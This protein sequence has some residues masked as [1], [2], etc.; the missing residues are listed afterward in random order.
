VRLGLLVLLI[1]LAAQFAFSLLGELVGIVAFRGSLLNMTSLIALLR[2]VYLAAFISLVFE[3]AE[4]VGFALCLFV[5]GDPGTRRMAL[6][7]LIVVGL[8]DLL[9][10]PALGMSMS[11]TALLSPEAVDAAVKSGDMLGIEAQMATL[12]T[13]SERMMWLAVV[14]GIIHYAQMIVVPVFLRTLVLELKAKALEKDCENLLWLN[15]IRIFVGIIAQLFMRLP[16]GVAML[17]FQLIGPISWLLG[18]VQLVWY[19]LL[20]FHIRTVIR[21]RFG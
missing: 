9:T 3:C 8:S 17:L 21:N 1:V 6:V 12:L 14:L 16:L 15:A 11:V 7:T 10:L 20:L 19:A 4:L 13:W 2:Y 5:P 18:L